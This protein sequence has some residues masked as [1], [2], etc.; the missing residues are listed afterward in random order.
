MSQKLP[1]GQ[2]R[3]R[4]LP[5]FGAHLSQPPPT[6]PDEPVIN[7]AGAVD[8]PFILRVADLAGLPRHEVSADLHCVSGWSAT[9]LHWEGVRFADLY[10]AVLEPSVPSASTVTRRTERPRRLPGHPAPGGPPGR[11]RAGRGPP[12][13]P[14]ARLRPRRAG[15]AGQPRPVRL[16]ER[17]APLSHRASRARTLA[18][19]PPAPTGPGHPEPARPAP[20][21]AGLAGGATPAAAG[22][23][24]AAGLPAHHHRGA[25]TQRNASRAPVI[26]THGTVLL[27]LCSVASTLALSPRAQEV[28]TTSRPQLWGRASALTHANCADVRRRRYDAPAY[29]A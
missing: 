20:P 7:V 23:A 27:D 5:R 15:P 6:V 13:R 17:Q 3:I 28:P 9:D 22:M 2:Y 18:P 16:H 12:R 29:Q 1:P 8:R 21:G 24:G 26:S 19:L 25:E 4:V 11:Q 14:A 10:R